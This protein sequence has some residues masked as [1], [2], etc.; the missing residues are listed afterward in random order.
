MSSEIWAFHRS[1]G[2][3]SRN[4][5]CHRSP[6][7]STSCSGSGSDTPPR[8]RLARDPELAD[9]AQQRQRLVGGAVVD[10]RAAPRRRSSCA[11]ERTSARSTCTSVR[12]PSASSLIVHSSAGRTWPGSSEAASSLSTGGC[13]GTLVSAP[14]S[15]SPRR[16][17]LEVDRVAGRDERGDVGDRVVHDV[18]VAVAREVHRLV[19]VARAGRVDRHERDVGAVQLGQ[20]RRGGRGAR[21]PPRPR[22]GTSGETSSSAWIRSMPGAQRRGGHPVIDGPD[23]D[24]ATARHTGTITACSSCC[25]PAR[26]RPRR[27]AAS[28]STSRPS[29]SPA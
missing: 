29:T 22:A 16:L 13:S 11:V 24:D 2:S 17:R 18:P 4:S 27:V 20:P 7:M 10:A 9:L 25:R 21:R 6:S 5:R 23:P 3:C 15:V 8:T 28:R 19:E 14:Y 1:T 26:A 12:A